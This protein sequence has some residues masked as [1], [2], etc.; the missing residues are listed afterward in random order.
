VLHH[1]R[2]GSYDGVVVIS[3]WGCGPAHVN[4]SLLRHQ[5][6]IPILFLYTD[7]TPMDERRLNA[8]A[9][10]LRRSPARGDPTPGGLPLSLGSDRETAEVQRA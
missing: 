5:R 8:F 9:F 6:E 4:E 3:P 1:W 7:G 10:R 2:E